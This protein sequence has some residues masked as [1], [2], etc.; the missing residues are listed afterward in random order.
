[1]KTL[2]FNKNNFIVKNN[3]SKALKKEI[4]GMFYGYI[5][6]KYNV[7]LDFNVFDKEISNL[8]I[9]LQNE[10]D[11]RKKQKRK[12]VKNIRNFKYTTVKSCWSGKRFIR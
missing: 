9:K 8:I 4:K 11:A 1:M 2:F 3:F 7:P 5:N 6:S 10:E 12:K